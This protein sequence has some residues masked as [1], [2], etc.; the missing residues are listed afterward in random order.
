MSEISEII[1]VFPIKFYPPQSPI[2]QS[3][4]YFYYSK[5]RVGKILQVGLK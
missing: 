1:E 5:P 3:P 2:I 4:Y